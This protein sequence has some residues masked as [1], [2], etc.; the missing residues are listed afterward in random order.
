[1]AQDLPHDLG[2]GE[3]R[4]HHHGHGPPCPIGGQRIPQGGLPPGSRTRRLWYGWGMDLFEEFFAII[5]ALDGARIRYAVVGGLAMAFHDEPRFTR[6]IDFLI[7]PDD[8]SRVPATMMANGYVEATEPWTFQTTPL[9]LHRYIRTDGEDHLVVDVLVGDQA[10]Y[11][12]I[13]EAATD[14]PWSNG[15]ARVVRREDLIWLK[16]QRGSDQDRLDIRRLQDDQNREG[17]SPG[18]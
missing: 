9:T 16:E 14:E 3:K 11:R 8:A 1:M 7:H 5:Q 4:Q 12:E 17:S 15:T 10:R 18:E 6:D 13:V 2:I